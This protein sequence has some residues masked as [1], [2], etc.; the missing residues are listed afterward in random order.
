MVDLTFQ[1]IDVRG[2]AIDAAMKVKYAP[3]E[4]TIAKGAQYAEVATP[5]LELPILQFVR[6]DAATLSMDLFFDSTEGG[7][8]ATA[9]AVTEDVEKFH[10][11][12]SIK[13]DLHYPPLV[14]ITWGDNFPGANFGES[15]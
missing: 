7:T 5:G 2:K 8:G 1:K 14:Q 3:A 11:L 6:G 4:L 12:V 13:G 10:K 15:G 9:T